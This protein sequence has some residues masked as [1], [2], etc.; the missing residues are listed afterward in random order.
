MCNK[1]KEQTKK[2]KNFLQKS[3]FFF[4]L[5]FFVDKKV[6]QRYQ[7]KS[8]NMSSSSLAFATCARAP[9]P[10]ATPAVH[11]LSSSAS[12]SRRG[13]GV[14]AGA[15]RGGGG[16]NAAFASVLFSSSHARHHQ[17][18]QHRMG[19]R[20]GENRGSIGRRF[21]GKM[22]TMA[23]L[24]S[25]SSSTMQQNPDGFA[26]IDLFSPSK[27]NLFLRIVRRRED[28]Y[29]DLAS[30]FH[31]IDLGD[32]MSFAKSSSETKDTLVCEDASIPLDESNL[33][34]KALNLFRAKTGIKQYFWVELKKTVPS[35]AGLG[36]GSGNAATA[37]YAANKLC[38]DVATEEELLEWSGDIGS[39]ISVFFST[40]AAY[41][42]GRGEIV[43][44][45]E[46]P[47]PL[48]TKM[49]LVKPSI[50]LSTPTIF[51][52]LDLD[53]RSKAEPLDLLKSLNADGCT[54][55]NAINDLERPAFSKLPELGELKD[56][57]I[58]ATKEDGAVVFMS[59]SGSTIV[60][61]GTDTVPKFAM[62]D[63]DLFKSKARLISRKKGEW[64]VPSNV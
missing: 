22:T 1:I 44:D 35:G 54:Y 49:C 47:L 40:G 48:T 34:I 19:R 28:G 62:E 10:G 37:L 30:L 58:D 9:T 63:D 24:S 38:G 41:C 20:G 45:V 12:S 14:G 56:K 64:F 8:S 51:K 27:I 42:T 6:N 46:P 31:V 60:L 50:G 5:V 29:H 59:G 16:K 21:R 36:G 18:H 11:T 2:R 32:E 26:Q 52:A 39:D 53:K 55:E 25:S 15:R 23:S 43:E 57:L 33:V 4:T 7:Q 3:S 61:L 13:G 17:Q